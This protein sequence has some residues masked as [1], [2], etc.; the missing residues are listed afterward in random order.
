MDEREA[1]LAALTREQAARAQAERILESKASELHKVNTDLHAARA[2]LERRVEAADAELASSLRRLELA[3]E[4]S[5][6]GTFEWEPHRDLVHADARLRAMIGLSS[7]ASPLTLDACLSL[8]QPAD[9]ATFRDALAKAAAGETIDST[10]RTLQTRRVLAAHGRAINV[11]SRGTIVLAL[12][13]DI[14]RRH[15]LEIDHRRLATHSARQERLVLL[16]E[17]ASTIAHEVNQPLAAI[18]NY[19]SAC[20]RLLDSLP[21]SRDTMARGLGAIVT[22]AEAASRSIRGLRGMITSPGEGFEPVTV[23]ALLTTA[24]AAVRTEAA[25]HG[26]EIT[27]H[28]ASWRLHCNRVLM[29]HALMNL[30]RNAVESLELVTGPRRITLSAQRD[31]D[32]TRLWIDDTG[33]GLCGMNPEEIFEPLVSGRRGGSGMGLALCR[34]VAEQHSGRARCIRNPEH[35]TGL[36]FE[37]SLPTEEVCSQPS[38]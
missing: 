6:A 33:P 22:E 29:E 38:T 12:I 25:D 17:F 10:F 8:L 30:V 11:P 31:A 19:A 26:V 36:R 34:T 14:T 13:R 27:L 24:A 35:P 16:G 28:P 20:V 1:L 21:A 5:D 37:I 32:F 15:E 9:A 23:D 18:V 3:L 2:A 7:D 4:A